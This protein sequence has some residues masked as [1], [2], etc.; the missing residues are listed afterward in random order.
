MTRRFVPLAALLALLVAGV[1]SAAYT[2]A[3]D[4]C[5]P[6]AEGTV[7]DVSFVATLFLDNA[8]DPGAPQFTAVPGE[9]GNVVFTLTPPANASSPLNATIELPATL[10]GLEWLG[11]S[12][13]ELSMPATGVR[14][15]AFAFR[16]APGASPGFVKVDFTLTVQGASES[17][18]LTL[19]VV[20]AP[21][22]P[23]EGPGTLTIVL[24]VGAAALV[25]GGAAYAVARARKPK[26]RPKSETLQRIEME[27]QLESAKT[28]EEKQAIREEIKAVEAE[29]SRA[30]D[31]QILEAKR[32][33]VERT[34]D[35]LKKRHDAGQ[36]T[37]LQYEKMV[38]KKLD[39]LDRINEEL[40]AAE[41]GHSSQSPH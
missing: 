1:A 10:S 11:D 32:A 39:E 6:R 17:G 19:E 23:A 7:G 20:P 29:K 9:G 31:L 37:R 30:R 14:E 34:I 25:I 16:V 22:P 13:R 2:Q 35:L 36:L 33:D 26:A 28:V 41:A 5:A 40:V 38:E 12:S 18:V 8:T 4:G 3:C 24:G 27:K 21:S 15:E